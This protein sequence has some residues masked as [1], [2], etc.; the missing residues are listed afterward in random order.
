MADAGK[1]VHRAD[2]ATRRPCSPPALTRHPFRLAQAEAWTTPRD[3]DSIEWFASANDIC[4]VYTSSPASLASRAVSD[5]P[6]LSLNDGGLRSTLPSGRR[7][8]S[9]AGRA[10]VLTL[11]YLAT[12]RP[13]RATSSSPHREP[14]EA[15]RRGT[16]APAML[17]VIKG[18]FTLAAG[19]DACLS[20][21]KIASR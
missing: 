9:R 17:S 7:P 4:R 10:R 20:H 1:A 2:E 14:V 16:A 12:P 8:G 3:I 21:D 11:A 18:A 15:H 19:S 5:R 13:G 6:V